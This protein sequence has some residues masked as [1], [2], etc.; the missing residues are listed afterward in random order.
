ML[1]EALHAGCQ[2]V[3]MEVSSQ[4]LAAERLREVRLPLPCSPTQ[5]LTTSTS[6]TPWRPYFLAKKRLFDTIAAQGGA[7]AVINADDPHGRQLAADPALAGHVVTFGG[8]PAAGP[9]G[10]YSVDGNVFHVSR[11]HAVG[12]GGHCNRFRRALQCV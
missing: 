5:A 3:A 4:G 8:D 9:R 10:G 7:P 11:Y 12:R 6:I 2:A 1:A